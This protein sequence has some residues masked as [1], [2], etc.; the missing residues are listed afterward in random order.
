MSKLIDLTK[1]AKV[2][3]E[4]KEIFGE[5][6]QV[7]YITDI[8]VSMSSLYSNGTVQELTDRLL[9]IGMN[10]D[11][12]KSIDVFAFGRNA[13]E[14]GSVTEGNHQGFVNN[15]LLQKVS[16][17]GST[18]YAGV[19][20][21]V[22]NK[23]GQ[24]VKKGLLSRIMGSKHSEKP[25]VPTLVF[26]ITDGDNFDKREAEEIIRKSSNQAIFWQFVGIG[27]AS[28]DFLQKLDD[29]S[30][31]FLD[32]ADFFNVNDLRRISDEE[33]MDRILNEFPEWIN[34]VRNKGILE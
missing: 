26:F 21:M 1:K 22:V 31:R 34:Q 25:T 12:D 14:V 4:K 16:L 28:F 19:M 32:N 24:P 5:K 2:V 6:A 10:L 15:V 23:Y 3:L 13:H 9:G 17:E 33:F 7:V 30:G 18:N 8:S 27:R 29:M 11:V 20:D